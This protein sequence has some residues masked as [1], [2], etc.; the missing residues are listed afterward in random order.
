MVDFYTVYW[1]A[2]IWRGRLLIRHDIDNRFLHVDVIMLYSI[3]TY[4]TL[5]YWFGSSCHSYLH[6]TTPNPSWL[7]VARF[8][9]GYG[10]FSPSSDSSRVRNFVSHPVA[11]TMLGVPRQLCTA[12]MVKL[13]NAIYHIHLQIFA[14]FYVLTGVATIGT[15]T[16][17]L[18]LSE[19]K[20]ISLTHSFFWNMQIT[21]FTGSNT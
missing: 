17:P 9:V 18:N 8:L 12:I 15:I 10:D 13:I 14:L 1:Q 20:I 11:F 19:F 16:G 3:V 7:F 4:L 2:D 21:V 6:P 5:V